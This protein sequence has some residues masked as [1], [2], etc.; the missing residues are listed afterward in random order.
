MFRLVVKH[1]K[2]MREKDGK[3]KHIAL[4]LHANV[5]QCTWNLMKKVCFSFEQ[6]WGC[7]K[8]M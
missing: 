3:W 2:H 1:E 7:E 8:N 6:T 4:L 5:S